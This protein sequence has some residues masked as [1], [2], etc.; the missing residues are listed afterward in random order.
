MRGRAVLGYADRR[1]DGIVLNQSW[2]ISPWREPL[3]EAH[4]MLIGLLAHEMIHL[5]PPFGSHP[6]GREFFL[7]ASVAARLLDLPA[8]ADPALVEP[9]HRA[10]PRCWPFGQMPASSILREGLKRLPKSLRVSA[11]P[12]PPRWRDEPESPLRA[13]C[14]TTAAIALFHATAMFTA[15]LE[16]SSLPLHRPHGS[17]AVRADVRGIAGAAAGLPIDDPSSSGID[18]TSWPRSRPARQAQV[19]VNRIPLD[20]SPRGKPPLVA[21]ARDNSAAGSSNSRDLT[22]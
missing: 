9:E 20:G 17:A 4:Q 12:S 10:H 1:L 11:A 19:R 13:G 6:H 15:S 2:I 5:V 16:S 7:M 8:P 18:R 14:S 3:A 22:S 21:G